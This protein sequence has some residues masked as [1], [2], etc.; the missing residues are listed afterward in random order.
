MCERLSTQMNTH[1]VYSEL[2]CA[3][4]IFRI[5]HALQGTSTFL[6]L[7]TLVA[8]EYPSVSLSPPTE[9]FHRLCV[10]STPHMINDKFQVLSRWLG[11]QLERSSPSP[12][13]ITCAVQA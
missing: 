12:M 11:W 4:A 1:V 13:S 2:Q 6:A 5:Q 9:P 7:C 3:D 8:F 10:Y